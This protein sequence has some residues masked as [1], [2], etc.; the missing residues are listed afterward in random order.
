MCADSPAQEAC[1][2]LRPPS[3]LR[4]TFL[5]PAE[6]TRNAGVLPSFPQEWESPPAWMGTAESEI[7][8]RELFLLLLA[9]G[10]P[11][12]PQPWSDTCDRVPGPERVAG[13]RAEPTVV[14]GCSWLHCRCL[15]L[16]EVSCWLRG[17]SNWE[18]LVLFASQGLLGTFW[19]P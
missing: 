14:S 17:H 7:W 1:P 2:H 9:P 18:D 13:G 6:L 4:L 5:H 19:K 15:E 12:L 8:A 3:P 11:R 10:F 16:R